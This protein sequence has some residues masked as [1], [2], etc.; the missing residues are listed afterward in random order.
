MI[1]GDASAEEVD[2]VKIVRC[3]EVQNFSLEW[4]LSGDEFG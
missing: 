2:G 1:R 3:V 4:V